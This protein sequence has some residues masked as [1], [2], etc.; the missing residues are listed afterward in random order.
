[1]TEKFILWAQAL[2]NA[3][4][5]H[6][7]V[8]GEELPADDSTRRQAAVSSVSTVIKN[9]TRIYDV[10]GVVLTADDRHFVLEVP[11]SQ[12]DHAGRTAP[13][14]C[15]GEYEAAAGDTLGASATVAV[16]DFAKCIG[17]TLQPEQLE[18]A[19]KSFEALK[20]KFSRTKLLQRAGIGAVTLVVLAIVYWLAQ[21]P[22]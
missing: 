6:F 4:P 11:S 1:M 16:D 9:G 2:D 22:G 8:R 14:V 19:R 12:R 5:D 21:K 13:I 15:F 18:H 17:R 20:K 3:S 7:E 10:S